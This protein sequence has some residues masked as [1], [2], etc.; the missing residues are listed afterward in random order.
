[1]QLAAQRLQ[2]ELAQSFDFQRS[3]PALTYASELRIHLGG[4]EIRLYHFGP[5]HTDGDT[6]VYFTKANVA[7]WGDVFET[8]S[9]PFIDRPAGAST[10]GWLEFLGR[11]LEAVGPAAKMIPGHGYV[12]TADDVKAVRQY[13]A[14]LRGAVGRAIAAGKTRDEAIASVP[15]QFPQYQDFRPGEARFRMSVGSIYDEMKEE[16]GRA[17]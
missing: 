16:A 14:D 17:R 4:E 6:L 11:G 2:L 13:F 10:R 8:H 3:L 15:A 9:H 12:A 5:A 1:E 7:H